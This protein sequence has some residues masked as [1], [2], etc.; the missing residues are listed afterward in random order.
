MGVNQETLV[1]GPKVT[2]PS[3]SYDDIKDLLDIDDDIS[4]D[5]IKDDRTLEQE[6]NTLKVGLGKVWSTEKYAVLG[7]DILGYSQYQTAEQRL[8]PFIFERI[9]RGAVLDLKNKESFFF[10][11]YVKSQD[12]V[13]KL[14]DTFVSTGDGGFQ[15]FETP[16]HALVFVYYL[17]ARLKQFN[18]FSSFPALRKLVGEIEMRFCISY[19]ELIGFEGNYF[20]KSII[21]N[22]RIMSSDKLNRLLIEDSAYEWF[23]RSIQ[24]LESLSHLNLDKIKKIPEFQE[25]ARARIKDSAGALGS[26]FFLDPLVFE[27]VIS[28]KI[29]TIQA[30]EA[31]IEV[32]NVAISSVIRYPRGKVGFTV[33][34]SNGAGLLPKE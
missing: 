11:K 25:G 16:L 1:G 7:S 19:G 26:N 6:A 22:A 9:Y 17:S 33:G 27:K 2:V 3:A 31:A 21:N 10:G 15:I 29:G 24:G 28:Q 12:L 30:K 4:P 18:T 5:E 34:N 8:I 23:Q 13:K 32:Y 20:G 14:K